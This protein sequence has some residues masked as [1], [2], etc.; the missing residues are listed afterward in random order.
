METESQKSTFVFDTTNK[1]LEWIDPNIYFIDTSQ[2]PI[3]KFYFNTFFMIYREL[4]ISMKAIL[5]SEVGNSVSRKRR[6]I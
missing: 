3:P 4:L 2:L 5:G 1:V 6:G